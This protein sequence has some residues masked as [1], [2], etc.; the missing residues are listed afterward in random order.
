MGTSGARSPSPTPT[1]RATHLVLEQ[2]HHALKQ[3]V[4]VD[5]GECE[6]EEEAVEHRLGDPL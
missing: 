5:G 1:L 4:A 3:L 2:Q 6:I